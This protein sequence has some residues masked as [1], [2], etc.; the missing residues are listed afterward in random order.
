MLSMGTTKELGYIQD[1]SFAVYDVY[2]ITSHGR[3][4]PKFKKKNNVKDRYS[5]KHVLK[6]FAYTNRIHISE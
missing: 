2:F 1:L 5:L 3:E 6:E 4:I